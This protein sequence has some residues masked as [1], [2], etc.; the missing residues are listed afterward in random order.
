MAKPIRINAFFRDVGLPLRHHRQSWGASDGAVVL[1]K[2]WSDEWEKS[3]GEVPVLRMAWH[4][5]KEGFGL[6]ERLGHLDALWTGRLA[7]Y[8][9]IA[10]STNAKSSTRTSK[11]L[12]NTDIYPITA[13]RADRGGVI[14]AVLASPISPEHLKEHS[15]AHRTHIPPGP[16][17]LSD[18]LQKVLHRFVVKQNRSKLPRERDLKAR[19]ARFAS[20]QVRPEQ[21]A[22]RIAIFRACLGRCVVSGCD[23]P[24]AVEAAHLKGRNWREGHNSPD[25]G[26]LLRRDLHALYDRGLLEILKDGTVKVSE[27]ISHAYGEFDTTASRRAKAA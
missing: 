24:E 3:A 2:T 16:L 9:L 18:E 17:P 26:I 13:L 6:R 14:T 19:E 20:V 7:G 15:L 1:L 10:D 4:E 12:R 22:F 21:A 23:V 5:G 8:T 25:D 27:I 11:P